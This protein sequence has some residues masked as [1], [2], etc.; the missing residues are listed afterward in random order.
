[1]KVLEVQVVA[2]VPSL[3]KWHEKCVMVLP[4]YKP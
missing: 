4:S 2:V 1:M 3:H